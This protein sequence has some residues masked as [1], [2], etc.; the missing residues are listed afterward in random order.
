MYLIIST[1]GGY[2]GRM[3][4]FSNRRPIVSTG[5]CSANNET[6][7]NQI[8]NL[9]QKAEDLQQRVSAIE[10]KAEAAGIEPWY[11]SRDY[12]NLIDEL[13]ELLIIIAEA[14]SND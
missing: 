2:N 6:L 11:F 10:H 4:S 8:M 1:E 5:R 7:E 14:E 13:G 9:W 12:G 3:D